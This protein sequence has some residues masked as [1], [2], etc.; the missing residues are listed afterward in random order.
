MDGQYI[1]NNIVKAEKHSIERRTSTLVYRGL[2]EIAE[3]ETD[4][5]VLRLIRTLRDTNSGG[6]LQLDNAYG[7]ICKLGPT[8]KGWEYALKRLVSTKRSR[9][10]KYE[11]WCCFYAALALTHHGCAPECSV[12]ALVEMISRWFSRRQGIHWIKVSIRAISGYESLSPSLVGQVT[13]VLRSI[14]EI[15][16]KDFFDDLVEDDAIDPRV[17]TL[18]ELRAE[19]AAA[20][21]L[22]EQN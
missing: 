18:D 15:E 17:Q 6:L 5:E 22:I 3:L 19:A 7:Q 2:D 21:R 9:P 11:R 13:P 8:V 20:M 10:F 16:P 12:P 14:L 1:K 4:P